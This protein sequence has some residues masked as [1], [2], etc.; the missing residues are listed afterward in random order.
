MQSAGRYDRLASQEPCQIE[1]AAGTGARSG[2]P[3]LPRCAD[4]RR[5]KRTKSRSGQIG[6]QVVCRQLR[7]VSSQPTRSRQG[8][9]Q[10]HVAPVPERALREQRGL[11]LGAR[12]LPRVCRQQPARPVASRRQVSASCG[13]HVAFLLAA[14]HAGAGTLARQGGLAAHARRTKR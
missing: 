1:F 4:R 10:T 5:R 11:G 6:R 13:W 8:P 9:F 2:C 7:V 3:W 14:T 12:L